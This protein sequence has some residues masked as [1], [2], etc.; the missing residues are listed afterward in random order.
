MSAPAGDRAGGAGRPARLLTVCLGN[1]CR[2]PTAE[3]ALVEAAAEF[4]IDV[5]VASAGTGDWHLGLPPNPPMQ[6]AA[7]QQGLLLRG[8]AQQVD[9]PLL[10]WAD[11]VLVMDRSNLADVTRIATDGGVDTPIALFRRFDPE[12]PVPSAPGSTPDGYAPDEVPDPYGGGAEGFD[13]VV[14]ICR[15]TARAIL[16]AWPEVASDLV[17]EREQ[18]GPR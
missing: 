12:L 2:S 15:R 6:A 13:E 14:R 8:T 10:A 17:T 18:G 9:V 3:A 1:I 5:E 7:A 4:G 11:L 16:A